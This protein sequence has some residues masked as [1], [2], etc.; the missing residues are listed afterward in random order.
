MSVSGGGPGWAW[1]GSV[2]ALFAIVGLVGTAAC[3]SRTSML[4]PD[5]YIADGQGGGPGKGTTG[6]G[7]L[8]M[9]GASVSP[10]APGSGVDTSLTKAPCEQYCAGYGTQCRQRLDGKNCIT[11]CQD[12]LN[13]SGPLCQL[14]GIETLS[15][16]TPF[17]SPKGGDCGSAVGRALTQCEELVSNFDECKGQ[18]ASGVKNAVSACPRMTDVGTGA[19]CISIFE[20]GAGPYVTFCSPTES[21]QFVKCDC[22]PPSGIP[23]SIRIPL[24]KDTCLDATAI[25]R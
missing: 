16:L 22:A 12:E 21:M 14:L 24:S 25:C 20:C 6:G 18:F 2:T 7:L 13:G 5:V 8:G 23:T 3:G 1:V 9:A 19:G 10:S 4:D 11:S 15:C 17:F